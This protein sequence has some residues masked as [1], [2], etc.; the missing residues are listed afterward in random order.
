MKQELLLLCLGEG[1]GVFA[2]DSFRG[3]IGGGSPLL[4]LKLF[5]SQ[6]VAVVMLSGRWRGPLE[7]E[8]EKVVTSVVRE[9]P[10]EEELVDIWAC[11]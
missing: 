9:G 6:E 4:G 1:R 8:L 5:S 2:G 3:G 11:K 10:G 7:L